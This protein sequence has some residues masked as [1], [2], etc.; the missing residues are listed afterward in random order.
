MRQVPTKARAAVGPATSPARLLLLSLALVVVGSEANAQEQDGSFYD[1]TW[2]V[3][4][5]CPG[6]SP[7]RARLVV[8]EYGGTWQ[9]LSGPR[10]V[11]KVC[12]GKKVP[13]TV[14]NSTRSLLAFTVFGDVVSPGCPTLTVVVKPVG[15]KVL[16]GDV[17]EGSH[18]SESAEV[19]ARHTAPSGPAAAPSGEGGNA[20]SGPARSAPTIRLERR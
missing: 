4:L 7:C 6:S 14:Q 3:R 11:K 20:A 15:A 18:A 17:Q 19:H 13:L 8:A 9:D 10:V 2:A 16:E 12:A 5:S 1:G